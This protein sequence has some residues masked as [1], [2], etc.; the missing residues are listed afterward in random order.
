MQAAG[1]L[2][3]VL[4]ELTARMELGHDDLG[5]RNP[6]FGMDGNRNAATIIAHRAGAIGVQ[7]NLDSVAVA[8]QRLV[9]GVIDHLVHH[10]VQTRAIVG[11]ANIHARALAHGIQ[12]PQD[13]NRISAVIG[14]AG[15]KRVTHAGSK[16]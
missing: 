10:V 16:R 15:R 2:V 12:A 7:D 9:N 4:V 6:L 13:L 1:D 3:G 14:Y 11:V 8:R 5:G